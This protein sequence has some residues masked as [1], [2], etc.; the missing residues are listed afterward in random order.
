MSM[1]GTQPK[2]NLIKT[3]PFK[4]NAERHAEVVRI[5]R[6]ANLPMSPAAKIK[7]ALVILEK[8][9]SINPFIDIKNVIELLRR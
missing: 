5:G 1:R 6:N 7:A 8:F 3:K 4:P 9:N 2:K